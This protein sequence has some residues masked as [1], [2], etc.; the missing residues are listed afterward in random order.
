MVETRSQ[1]AEMEEIKQLL[2]ALSADAAEARAEA[3]RETEETRAEIAEGL[4]KTCDDIITKTRDEISKTRDEIAQEISDS[5]KQLAEVFEKKLESE[6]SGVKN[7]IR[8]LSEETDKI[9]AEVEIQKLEIE[10]HKSM[11]EAMDSRISSMN[12]TMDSRFSNLCSQMQKLSE[13]MGDLELGQRFM[14]VRGHSA[15][16][17]DTKVSVDRT[18]KN[19][20]ADTFDGKAPLEQYLCQFEVVAKANG[21]SEVEKGSM[22]AA[23][24]RG[25]AVGI[26]CNLLEHERGNYAA[27]VARLKTRY[28]TSN[29]VQLNHHKLHAR[30]QGAKEDLAQYAFDV[31]GLTR[32][33]FQGAPMEVQEQVAVRQFTEGLYSERTQEAVILANPKTLREALTKAVEVES[34]RQTFRRESRVR[35][36]VADEEEEPLEVGRSQVKPVR[37]KR[38]LICWRCNKP[39]HIQAECRERTASHNGKAPE[40]LTN[41]GNA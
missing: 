6:V 14:H 26:L 3:R 2:A 35:A 17:T 37:P 18:N 23:S 12:E 38:Q 13:Q 7:Q 41:Q 32:L 30:R 28:G 1:T 34:I 39:G 29:L 16:M 10:M 5:N 11:N 27:L 36:A 21:W 15:E 40:R 8:E 20:K 31:E 24:L 19:V 33:S 4:T 22:L 9:A 25:E